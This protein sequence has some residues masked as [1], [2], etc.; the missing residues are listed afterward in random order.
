MD[1]IKTKKSGRFRDKQ[2][3]YIYIYTYVLVRSCS[4]GCLYG[5]LD[6]LARVRLI[7]GASD[8]EGVVHAL[9]VINFCM[10][11]NDKHIEG[12]DNKE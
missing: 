10:N 1:N 8:H 9:L 11:D 2:S 6:G 12:M 3:I 5:H 4:Y 7:E